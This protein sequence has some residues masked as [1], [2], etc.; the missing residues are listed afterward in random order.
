MSRPDQSTPSP[1]TPRISRRRLLA[2][3]AAAGGASATGAAV[4]SNRDSSD[5]TS[6]DPAHPRDSVPTSTGT[7]PATT[8]APTGSPSV[9]LS[10]RLLVVVEMTGGNDGLSMAVPYADGSYHD[11]RNETKIAEADVL[12]IDGTIGLHPN[13]STLHERGV[14]L[15]EGVGSTVPDGS[16][17]EMQ[18]RWWAGDSAVADT[19]T[20]WIGRLADVLHTDGDRATPATGLAIGAGAHP[21]IRSASGSTV[22]MPGADALRSFAGATQTNDYMRWIYQ[23]SLR[24]FAAAE[25]PVA[26]TLAE[27]IAFAERMI[28][29]GLDDESADDLS[30]EGGFGESLRFAA[31]VLAGGVG[32]RVIHVS[33]EGDYDTHQNHSYKHPLLMRELD[34]NLGAFHRELDARGLGDRVMVMTTSEFGRTANENSSGGLDHGTAST[35]LLSGPA[36]SGR[37]G[38]APSLTDLDENDDL[39]ATMA[40]ESYLG[41]V[42]EGWLGVPASE[43]FD[44]AIA[45]LDLF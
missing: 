26:A 34:T 36:T 19:S 32:V 11:L 43:I 22:S 9:D 25:G 23:Q 18:A 33:T 16:H 5:G 7:G 39:K 4:L 35:M 2:L 8:S 45:P 44:P 42:V 3:M 27:T 30:Y 38:D 37:F 20:G 10:D 12:D 41:G 13:L 15:V 40:F 24:G 6:S 28:E 17:F 31:A 21:I 14:A 1:T 29:T